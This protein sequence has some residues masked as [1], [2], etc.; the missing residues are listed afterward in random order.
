MLV[1]P[2][3]SGSF[4]G[5]MPPLPSGEY[6]VTKRGHFDSGTMKSVSPIFSGLKMRSRRNTLNGWPD[7][8]STT[9]PS[10]S[11]ERL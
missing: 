1:L 7:T 6:T 9:R 10:T 8:T 4:I 5:L 11:V 3:V 2:N